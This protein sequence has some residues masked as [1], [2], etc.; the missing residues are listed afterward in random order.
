MFKEAIEV[1]SNGTSQKHYYLTKGDSCGII[2]T[3]FIGEQQVSPEKID[4]VTFALGDNCL[5]I[6]LSKQMTLLEDGTYLINL[7]SQDTRDLKCTTYTYTV[8]YTLVDGNI[9]TT[10]QWY[11]DI[12][13][14]NHA[15]E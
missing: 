2:S 10:N 7:L 11:F 14:T 6:V 13:P 9:S 3:P 1:D 5:H 15:E 12:L 8:R 4:N